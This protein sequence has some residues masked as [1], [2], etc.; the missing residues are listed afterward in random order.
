MYSFF[1]YLYAV[2]VRLAAWSGNVKAGQLAKGQRDVWSQMKASLVAGEQR[3]WVHCASVGEFEQGR[4]LMEALRAGYPQYKIALTFFS[5]SGY[6]LQKNYA[7]ADYIF[8]LPYD[9]R[10]NAKRFVALLQPQKV[11]FIKYEFWP[12]YLRK[13]RQL[14]IPFYLVSANFRAKQIFFKW[15]GGRYRKLLSAFT[16]FFVQNETSRIL[17]AHAGFNNA[18][19]TGDTRF[20]R[21]C[22][23]VDQAQSI[24]AVAQ[25]V[26]GKQC[27][28][29]GSTWPPDVAILTRYI[30]ENKNRG[31]KW[32]FAPHELHEQQIEALMA[33]VQV[34][35]VRYSRLA[36]SNAADYDVLVID[37]IGML[38]ALY[39][40]GTVAYIGG[41]FG[42]GIHN[43]LEAAVY[44]IPVFFGPAYK[45][46]QEAVDL[47]EKGGAF[48]VKNYDDFARKLNDFLHNPEKLKQA[49]KIAGDFVASGRGATEKIIKYE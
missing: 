39:R 13:I 22:R 32:I 36:D 45:K 27:V 21:V 11:Y 12:N 37:N 24:P 38:S 44:G 1:I 2:L 19:V 23:I 34:K 30:N 14:Q 40:Y 16:R 25:F 28:V 46:F 18:T 29:A 5:P 26:Q 7:G 3:I 42:K 10:R 48:P 41:G 31:L 4:P 8:Y 47:S 49:G 43:T 35:A 15:Y 17:L 6:A 9:T 20:D 33:S